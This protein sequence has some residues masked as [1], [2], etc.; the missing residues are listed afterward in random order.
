M[1]VAYIL[2]SPRAASYQLAQMIL[3]QL[4]AGTHG[5]D[6]VG[7]FFFDDNTFVLRK[8][9]PVGERLSAVAQEKGMLLMMCDM[10]AL[11]RNLAE[12]EPRWCDPGTGEGRSEAAECSVKDT[13]D[14]VH[15]GCFPDLYAAL[16][17]SPPDQVITL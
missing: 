4:E 3:P 7:I 15:V 6:V 8:G 2:K 14:G 16:A 12:G 5:V 13:V 11:E 1:K 17:G 10:C 9:D